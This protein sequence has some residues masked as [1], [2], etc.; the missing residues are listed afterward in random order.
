MTTRILAVCLGNICRSPTA[1]AVLR[2]EAARAGVSV[3]VD[4]AGTSDWHIGKAPYGHAVSAAAKRGY[5]LTALRARQVRPEDFA[6][7]DLILA[8]DVDNRNAL[9]AMRNGA[10]RN[11]PA[12]PVRLF[13][14]FAEGAPM[15]SVPD[16][17]YSRDF[18]GT[19][20]LI[21]AAARGLI[22]QLAQKA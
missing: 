22:A 8:M 14:D 1:E 20:D 11:A 2:A 5:D 4:S 15:L 21:E 13:L 16:P 3:E 12:A 18:E 10:V 6:E 19:L 9:V 7:F 17:Y